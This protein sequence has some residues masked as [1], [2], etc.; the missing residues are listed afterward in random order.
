MNITCAIIDDEPLAR[1]LL[2]GYVDR[3]PF[4]TL[5][6]MYDSAMSAVCELTS[7]P[8][9]LVFM[10]IQIPDMD[11][12][13]F[14]RLLPS[15]TKVIF[16]T[17]FSEHA[18]QAF[19]V[20]AL[21]YLV[22]PINYAEFLESVNK[23]LAWFDRRQGNTSGTTSVEEKEEKKEKENFVFIKSDY[24]VIQIMLDD[25]LF[26]EGYKDYLKFYL[27]NDTT[28]TSLLNMKNVEDSLPASRFKRVHR[29]YIVQMSKIEYINK[30]M[31]YIGTHSIPIS[32][33]YKEEMN[34]YI[35][36]HLL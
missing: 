31:I 23:A 3:T 12:V 32:D 15:Q 33:G 34:Q 27:A 20:N 14:S 29:S 18:A 36:T 4:L 2:K 26:V 6:G 21:D 28:I 30:G 13:K 7:N 8:P 35:N 5:T 9:N 19:R 16:T 1:T 24:K 10:D 17:A 25:I 11:G 22:K